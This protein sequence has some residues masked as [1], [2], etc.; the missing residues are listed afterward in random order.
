MI[1]FRYRALSDSGAVSEGTIEALGER[2]AMEALK[3]RSL[4]PFELQRQVVR[5]KQATASRSLFG[6]SQRRALLDT[7]HQLAA[8]LKAGLSILSAIQIVRN[9][10]PSPRIAMQLE[11][12]ERDLRRGA[13]FAQALTTHF[14][15]LAPYVARF[16]DLGMQT[17]RLGDTLREAIDR[18]VFEDGVRRDISQALAYP[19]FLLGAGIAVGIFLF[20]S[21]LPRFAS[22]VKGAEDKV[23]GF[24]RALIN[25][26]LWLQENSLVAI[27]AVVALIAGVIAVT[28]LPGA[29]ATAFSILA[30]LPLLGPAIRLA[31]WATWSR[32]A[33]GALGYGAHLT[34][35]LDIALP[36]VRLRDLRDGLN[37]A[38]RKIRAGAN[39]EDAL[40]Q[41]A[42]ADSF[43]SNMT[44][45]GRLTGRLGEMLLFVSNRYEEDT[46]S[47]IRQLTALAEPVAIMLVAGLIGVVVI[48]VVLTISSVYDVIS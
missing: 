35:A 33:G 40:T 31:E 34:I 10:A 3:D 38:A 5:L 47:R 26:G 44:R 41:E 37:R 12:L 8:L 22:M 15:D 42:G 18:M 13:P 46:K 7:F 32:V 16:A 4:V 39:I 23:P 19:I 28:R 6:P 29:R 45:T 1:R 36:A 9:G 30:R 24:A 2:E 20:T 14:P 17:G 48:A 25:G 21:V 11:G 27:A 43:V